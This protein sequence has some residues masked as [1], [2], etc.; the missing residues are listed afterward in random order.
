MVGP[1]WITQNWFPVLLGMLVDRPLLMTASLN[2]SVYPLN[3]TSPSASQ[4]K[5]SSGLHILSNIDL[6]NVSKTTQYILLSIWSKSTRGRYNSV[7]QQWHDF[8]GK[9]ETNY[10]LPDVTSVL[11][12]LSSFMKRLSI[13][14]CY[15][16]M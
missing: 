6:Q 14:P 15:S 3:N 13:Q 10:L 2:I 12:W 7:L 11:N 9:E 1:Y 16:S 4:V 8:C 5:T